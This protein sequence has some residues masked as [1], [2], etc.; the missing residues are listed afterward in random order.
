M[1]SINK[2]INE[3]FV[4]LNIDDIKEYIEYIYNY[5]FDE[6]FNKIKNKNFDLKSKFR[7]IVDYPKSNGALFFNLGMLDYIVYASKYSSNK[8]NEVCNK[9]I[10][11]FNDYGGMTG[12]E[13]ISVLQ[14]VVNYLK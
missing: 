8:L 14:N 12:G 2:Y 11:N 7:N 1:K 3:S 13:L 9:V 4:Q 5:G 6:Y 10:K